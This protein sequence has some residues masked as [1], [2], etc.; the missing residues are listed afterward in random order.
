[1]EEFIV[2]NSCFE[3]VKNHLRA[4]A[5]TTLDFIFACGYIRREKEKS[6]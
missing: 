4:D 1:V 6:K 5:A 3:K 2:C